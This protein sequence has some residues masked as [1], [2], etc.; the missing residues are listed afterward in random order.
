MANIFLNNNKLQLL[1]MVKSNNFDFNLFIEKYSSYLDSVMERDISNVDIKLRMKAKREI[2]FFIKSAIQKGYINEDNKSKALE[3]LVESTS[4]IKKI[5][6]AY[7][8]CHTWSLGINFNSQELI[9]NMRHYLC[10]ELT[11]SITDLNVFI[12]EVNGKNSCGIYD[13]HGNGI[14]HILT[15][16]F[17]RFL[18]EVMAESTACDLAGSYC[19]EKTRAFLMPEYIKSDWH[20]PFNQ[21]YQQLGLEFVKAF[22]FQNSNLS[23][24]E[25]F[26]T[27][28]LQAINDADIGK[29]ILDSAQRKNPDSYKEDLHE[30]SN[31]LGK[32]CMHTHSLSDIE[33]KQ[34]RQIYDKY[35]K[36]I[37]MKH[38]PNRQSE[39]TITMTSRRSGK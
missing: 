9:D 21:A 34:I 33:V 16:N 37:T 35:Y 31:I 28:T 19:H 20:T 14:S 24:R 13:Y 29:M 17:L 10:H 6:G 32:L 8:I 30:I 11:H 15:Q 26:K 23:E 27:I 1:N 22:L 7:A 36:T 38:D 4:N 12:F 5:D 2:L 39:R 3:R 18:N 25:M